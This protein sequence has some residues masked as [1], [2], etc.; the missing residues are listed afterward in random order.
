MNQHA[1][2]DAFIMAADPHH[3]SRL[4][5]QLFRQSLGKASALRRR[6]KNPQPTPFVVHGVHR[7]K[8]GLGL[9]DHAGPAAVWRIIGDPMPIITE[10]TNIMHADGHQP[11]FLRTFDDGVGD[12]VLH[13]L[14]KQSQQIN[15][16]RHSPIPPSAPPS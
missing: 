14:G 5:T 11:F 3:S 8:N 1:F 15:A 16:Q 7:A 9:H 12:D 10:L 4:L 2:V 6:H 13:H